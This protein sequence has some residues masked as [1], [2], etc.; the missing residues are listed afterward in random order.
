MWGE[1]TSF[2]G[3]GIF[4]LGFFFVGKSTGEDA[5]DEMKNTNYNGGMAG[6]F[7]GIVL[8]IIGYFFRVTEKLKNSNY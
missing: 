3:F 7:I 2:L 8:S 4:L 1:I 5:K 6:I